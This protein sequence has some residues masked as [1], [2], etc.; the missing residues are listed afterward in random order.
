[1]TDL[2]YILYV[3]AVL[4]VLAA[5]AVFRLL[6]TLPAGC[7]A[8]RYAAPG[9]GYLRLAMLALE[10]DGPAPRFPALDRP[11]NRMLLAETL[12]SLVAST[13]GLDP[14]PLRR[15]VRSTKL[16]GWLLRRARLSRGYRRAHALA[17]LAMLPVAPRVARHTARYLGSRD[18]AVAFQAMMIRLAARPDRATE[19][20]AAYP[21]RFSAAEVARILV[22]LRRGAL[23]VA[24]E[25]LLRSGSFN[26]RRVGLAVVRQFA[27]SDAEPALRR[28]L[29]RESSD[30]L[31]RETLHTLCNLRC[32]LESSEIHARVAVLEGPDRRSLLRR[33]AREAYAPGAL[34]PLLDERERPYYES[35]VRSYKC[36][37][38]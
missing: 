36:S 34:R 29:A 11:G 8:R 18:R 27:L 38:A 22:E 32:P 21:F 30:E 10:S 23:P 14:A 16:D 4:L 1:M 28:M 20:M 15:I 2:F 26:L 19:T 33:M 24:C 35:L 17:L 12:A 25:P 37:L 13:Y 3:A 9:D 6:T 5:L 31:V 7:G